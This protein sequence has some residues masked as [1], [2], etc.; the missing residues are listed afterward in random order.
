MKEQTPAPTAPLENN[1]PEMVRQGF[2][3]LLAEIE[4]SDTLCFKFKSSV[5][6]KDSLPVL[7]TEIDKYSSLGEIPPE[8]LKCRFYAFMAVTKYQEIRLKTEMTHE[9]VMELLEDYLKEYIASSRIMIGT[10][11]AIKRLG[12]NGNLFPKIRN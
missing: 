2:M 9:K 6:R 7:T 1:D 4:R 3:N 11:K 12:A 10:I 8:E 5:I